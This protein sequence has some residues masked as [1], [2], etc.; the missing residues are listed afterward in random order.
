MKK[1]EPEFGN[2]PGNTF[3]VGGERV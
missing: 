3:K 2:R 1:A